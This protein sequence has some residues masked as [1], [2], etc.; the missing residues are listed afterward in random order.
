A[1]GVRGHFV[2]EM[3]R[4][5]WGFDLRFERDE[6][7]RS[8]AVAN[9]DHDFFYTGVNIDWDFSDVMT[10]HAGLRKY[11]TVYDDRPARDLTGALLDTNPAQ[12]YDHLGLQLGVERQ[13]GRAVE[14]AADYLR[15]DRADGFLGY[16]DYTQDV[17]RVRF[18][19][20]PT[21]RF[22]IRLALL[23]RSYDYP[24][25]FA[26]HVA[27]GGVRELEEA[28]MTLEAE[29]RF[30]PRLA[31]KARLDSVDVTSTDARSEYLRTRPM[32][33]VEWRK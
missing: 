11:R 10:L 3:G 8:S 24:N 5:T 28:G 15:L 31:L 32:L 12:E 18:G 33:G 29:Y 17:L 20:H 19:F 1:A 27:A 14:L 9:F 21:P 30:T 13:L 7:D 16:Y 2:H 4:I 23:A 26:Y 25:A 22:D 6:Y